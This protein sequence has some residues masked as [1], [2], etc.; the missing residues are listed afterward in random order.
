MALDAAAQLADDRSRAIV[1][2]ARWIATVGTTT[3]AALLIA[4]L[5]RPSRFYEMLR[6]FRPTSPMNMGTWILSGSG[7]T[8]GASAVLPLLGATKLAD[9]AGLT[10]ELFGLGLASYTGVLISATAV[11]AWQHGN[12][13]LPPLFAASATASTGA[14]LDL[15]G[16]ESR[17]VE[18]FGNVGK[19]AELALDFA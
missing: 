14:L 18:A 19:I 6:V 15:L 9:A 16:V 10:A 3:S 17:A 12:R 2:P 8:A 4:D 13:T 7:A 5:G 11:P 1:T